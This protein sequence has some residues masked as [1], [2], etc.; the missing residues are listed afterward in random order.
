MVRVV[1]CATPLPPTCAI[2]LNDEGLRVSTGFT[3]ED[4]DALPELD[5]QPQIKPVSM[6]TITK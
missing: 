4:R 6:A 2:K 5:P 3:A 1:L